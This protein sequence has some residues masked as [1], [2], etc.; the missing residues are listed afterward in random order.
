ME[1][2]NRSAGIAWSLRQGRRQMGWLVMCCLSL[3]LAGAAAA[4]QGED[5]EERL[6]EMMAGKR[7]VGSF[8]VV[9]PEGE[10]RPQADNYMVSELERGEGDRWIFVAR[11]GTGSN[12]I[13]LPVPV[14]VLW[15]GSTP[16]LTMTEQTIEGLGTFTARV[17]LHDGRYAGTWQ[18]G[19]VGGNMWG[20]IV[21]AVEDAE[22]SGEA[23]A[24]AG[25]DG[26][27]P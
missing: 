16:V 26:G 6:V 22:S 12:G 2:L 24:G 19:P 23:A 21:D 18:H 13:E 7:L 4:Q 10:S 15:A 9:T 3:S 11:M 25:V 14:E 17:L 27:T 20:R 1:S 5:P 8:S